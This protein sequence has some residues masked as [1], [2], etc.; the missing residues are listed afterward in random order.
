M[1]KRPLSVLMVVG[2]SA[3]LPVIGGCSSSGDTTSASTSPSASSAAP[4]TAAASLPVDTA[5]SSAADPVVQ[6]EW[7]E[8]RCDI[9][10]Q[11]D[12]E[13][14]LGASVTTVRPTPSGCEYL[15]DDDIVDFEF[16]R[17]DG[18]YRIHQGNSHTTP[19][20]GFGQSAFYSNVPQVGAILFVVLDDGR[21]FY[22]GSSA[23]VL[24]RLA[25]EV[26]DAA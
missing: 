7:P 26:I 5:E 15:N 9:V 22:V 1:N 13:A 23:D 6:N 14:A 2:V 12:V 11:T 17:D 4:E 20:P 24:D 10:A 25:T 21:S 18:E 16:Y 19:A 3:M 8:S